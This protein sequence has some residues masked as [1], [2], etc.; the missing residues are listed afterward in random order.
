MSPKEALQQWFGLPQFRSPQEEIIASVLQRRDT[1]VVMPTGGG[2][3]LCYQLPAMLLPGVT[4]IVSPLIALMKDQVD[5]LLA[6]GLPVGLINS[7]Q[8]AEEQQQTLQEL[9]MGKLKMLYVSPERFRA[10]SFTRSL[11]QTTI[12]LMAVDE[13]HCLSQWGHDFRPDYL[14]LNDARKALGNPPCIA[15]TATATPDVQADIRKQLDLRSPSEFVAGFERPNLQFVVSPVGSADEKFHH[16][17]D[18]LQQYRT[19]IVYCATRKSVDMVADKLEK[20]HG[21]V[22]RY[23]GG[24]ND[25]ERNEAQEQFMSKQLHVVVAT[26]AFGMGIDRSDIRFVCHFEMPGSI[27]A[28]YQ[29]AG[30]AGRDGKPS[31]CEMLF[32][33]ADKRVQ[34][35]FVDGSNPDRE[36]I[37]NVFDFLKRER[38]EQNEVH[39]SIDDITEQMGKKINPMAVSS[40]LALLGRGK[41]IER[42]D[43]PGKRMRGTRI[44]NTD[45]RGRNLPFDA[46]A[47]AEKRQRDEKRLQAVIQFAYARDCRQ[48]WILDYFGEKIAQ[49]CGRCDHCRSQSTRRVREGT[50]YEVEILRKLLSGIARMCTRID[51]DIW[52]ARF[53]KNKILLCV[54][55]S[56][57]QG[58]HDSH[59]SQLSTYGILKGTSR[60]YLEALMGEAE[61]C[62]LLATVQKDEFTLL[63][64]TPAGSLVMRGLQDALLNWPSLE[65]TNRKGRAD[66]RKPVKTSGSENEISQSLYQKLVAE[67][68]KIAGKRGIPAYTVFPNSVL[69]SLARIQPRNEDEASI[70]KGIGPAKT[71]SVLPAFLQIIRDHAII[72]H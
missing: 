21:P 26:N 65:T 23:H 1:L 13:A 32:S 20:I 28:Y 66:A 18:L 69:E 29:E 41:W 6:K 68:A 62:G 37:A 8:S 71:R 64:L 48:R 34:D 15:L 42:F 22:I 45:I 27:E 39:L 52:E 33:Y 25:K 4:L 53:G 12:S 55:G 7:M 14:R 70:I 56:K 31:I 50:P 51:T 67:R 72:H 2:K 19:G 11:A 58:V 63:E 30:R 61:T 9:R 3:S 40:A 17:T 5:N 24:M 54:L 57:A 44:L 47:L 10:P 35:F 36:L 43:I 46:S 16:L 60:D 49:T 38:D 59:L